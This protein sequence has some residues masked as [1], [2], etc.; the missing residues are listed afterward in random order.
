MA[1][2]PLKCIVS[3]GTIQVI[4]T[5]GLRREIVPNVTHHSYYKIYQHGK[6]PA[7]AKSLA[8]VLAGKFGDRR[9]GVKLHFSCTLKHNL[10]STCSTRI[11][12]FSAE[13]KYDPRI[14]YLVD[15]GLPPTKV[16]SVS[17]DRTAILMKNRMDPEL[18]KK[19]RMKMCRFLCNVFHCFH[20][21]ADN[22]NCI[23]FQ[24]KSHFRRSRKS[25]KHL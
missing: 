11:F 14:H 18:E 5:R 23:L 16:K 19:S 4:Q 9:F 13:N 8:E 10:Y 1:S 21:T 22:Q 7:T 12:M 3:P 6:S 15:I 25:G 20:W 2:K 17:A 24:W